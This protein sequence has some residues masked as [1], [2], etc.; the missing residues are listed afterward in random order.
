MAAL[1]RKLE[2]R[3]GWEEALHP[4]GPL[5]SLPFPGALATSEGGRL[6]QIGASS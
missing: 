3:A 2:G 5:P 6:H 1:T 4:G